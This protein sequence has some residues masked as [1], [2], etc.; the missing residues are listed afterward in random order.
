MTIGAQ[1][2][3][4]EPSYE[5][6]CV[7][8]ALRQ[9]L[10]SDRT[11]EAG[12]V[13]AF[14]TELA[15]VHQVRHCVGVDN[16]TN[17]IA[18]A[19]RSV[20]VKPG[21]EVIT[22]AN[23]PLHT[24][25]AID[26]L[27]AIPVFVDVDEGSFL[28]RADLI[29]DRV[30]PRTTCILPVHQ[31]GQC[32]DMTALT[33]AAA[34]FG[35]CVVEDCSHSLGARQDGRLAGMWGDAAAFS[36]GPSGALCG[37]GRAAAVLTAVTDR[38]QLLRQLRRLGTSDYTCVEHTPGFDAELDP[39]QAEVMRRS[40]LRLDA[41]LVARETIAANY[42][43]ALGDT[44]LTL[45]V[46]VAGNSH[47]YHAYVVR[48]PARGEILAKLAEAG[49]DLA[50]DYPWPAH[51]MPGFRKLRLGPGT[52]PVTEALAEETFFLPIRS[53]LSRDYQSRVIEALRTI[54]DTL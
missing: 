54:L 21:D 24:S 34:E 1:D 37:Y 49:L 14:E 31:Y 35:L 23:S 7:V 52:L 8:D 18:L 3:L 15:A 11:D 9:V 32:A 36:F 20:G 42:R 26:Q 4:S 6:S 51:R 46:T 2:Q 38:N 29:R 40:L 30:S 43:E 17:A 27:G 12:A 25:V 48:H 19:L 10:D 53:T 45:P 41:I 44:S 13:A 33:A 50:N 39:F 28:I 47:V 22:T 5:E 16:G